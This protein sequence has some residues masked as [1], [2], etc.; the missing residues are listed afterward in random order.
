M[1]AAKAT[2]FLDLILICIVRV[3]VAAARV[4]HPYIWNVSA[5]TARFRHGA[6]EDALAVEQAEA[7]RRGHAADVHGPD[8][9][10][11]HADQV[12]AIVVLR[13]KKSEGVPPALWSHKGAPSY[14]PSS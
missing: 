1:S 3:G 11:P 12:D 10:E 4:K 9:V 7:V 8:D 2:S 6:V 14:L 13:S 5:T